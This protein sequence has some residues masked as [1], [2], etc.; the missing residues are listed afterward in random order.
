MI[1]FDGTFCA[2]AENQLQFILAQAADVSSRNRV[3]DAR[4]HKV[5][6]EIALLVG[7]HLADAAGP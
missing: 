2:G 7:E 6:I 5:E 1:P 3:R 4:H